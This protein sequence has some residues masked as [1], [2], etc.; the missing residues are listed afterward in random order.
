MSDYQIKIDR[1][2]AVAGQFYPSKDKSLTEELNKL[3]ERATPK[4]HFNIRAIICPHAGYIYSGKVAASAYNQ[5]ADNAHYERVF[6]IAASHLQHFESASIYCA[7]DFLTPLGKLIVDIEFGEMLTEQFPHIFSNNSSPHQGEHS[8]EVQLP[9]LQHKLRSAFKIIPIIIGT[10]KAD[11]CKKIG[12]ALRPY[13]NDKNL[14]VISTD[15]SHYPK[16]IDAKMVDEITKN[17]ILSNNPQQLLATLEQNSK[18]QIKNLETSLCGWTAVL[19]LLYMTSEISQIQY[20]A[21]DYSNSGDNKLIGNSN[22]VVGY[23]SIAAHETV[24]YTNQFQLEEKDQKT[25]LKIARETLKKNCS[26]ES[27]L[28]LETNGFSDQLKQC[29]GVFVSLHKKGELRGCIGSI[30]SKKP[31]FQ[32]VQQM[33]IAA[34]SHDYRFR[35][36]E[37]EELSEVFIEISVLS[38]L[39]KIEDISEIIL[40]THGVLIESKRHSGVFLPQVAT[41]TGW[42]KE[43]LLGHCARDKAG[44]DWNGWKSADIYIFTATLFSENKAQSSYNQ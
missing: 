3:F 32:Q 35:P 25:L 42:N 26:K 13:L 38:P 40:G 17:A 24:E 41:E 4:K 19:T 12:D 31:L 5:I 8:I 10:H 1:K 15:F 21:I 39:K 30:T 11:S 20:T 28:Q 37:A 18:L 6:I 9:F 29:P 7:G 16:S 43:E 44:L 33:T 36:I 23:W 34:A 14:F 22:R 2:A 27:M